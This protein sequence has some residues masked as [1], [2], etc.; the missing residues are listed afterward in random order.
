MSG[1]LKS[2]SQIKQLLQLH[3]LGKNKK[4]IARSLGMSKNTVKV[5]LSKLA[6]SA[7]DIQSLLTLDDPILEGKFHAGNPAYKDERFDHFKTKLEYFSKELTRVGVTRQLLWEEYRSDYPGGYGHTQFCYH[8]S[9]Q[10]IARKPSMV[11][12]HRAAEKLFIDFAGKRLSYIDS[13][14]GEEVPCQ[15][16][17]ACL[18]YSDYSFAMVVRSQSVADFLYALGCCLEDLGGV[19]EVLVPDN[20]KSA[21][22]K[23]SSYEPDVNRAMEDFANHYKTTVIPARACK[24]KDKA[25]V[26]NQVKLIYTRIYARLRNLTFFDLPSLNKAVKEKIGDHNQT[27]MQQKPYCR[28]E[29]FLA[30]EKH[31][32]QP[33]PD[34]R[35]ELKY[36]RDL[37]VAKNNHIYLAQD[38]HYY[39]VLYTYIGLMVK[40]I[41]TRSMVYIY[42]KG[43]QIAVHVRDYKQ[44]GYTTDKEHLCSAHQHYMDRSPDYYLNKAKLKSEA[45]YQLLGHLFAQNRHPEQLYR[46]C[47]G[48]L[49]LQRKTDEMI[50]EKACMMAIEY[51][52][53]TYTFV[54]N[55]LKNKMTEESEIKQAK[56]LPTHENTRGR[57]YYTQSTISF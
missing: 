16:F 53:Y 23:A 32:L 1:K 30:D 26:E 8:L 25:L 27:R 54:L 31:L 49:N 37:K 48:L 36:Y 19:P 9:Q 14:T 43:E 17:V 55:I 5:Y 39:S 41:Y 15:V 52:N 10:L 22:V 42:A 38:K 40:V 7:L 50:F 21:I 2:M 12:Q 24:P 46:T 35:F 4:F 20:L 3:E 45:L 44:G 11:L 34:Q 13:D 56:P 28:E 51:Q 18:P 29:K 47:D 33:L 57:E 6:L